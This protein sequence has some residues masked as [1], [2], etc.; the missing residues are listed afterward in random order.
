MDIHF[1]IV[2]FDAVKHRG[3]VEALWREVFTYDSPRNMPTLVIAKKCA[4]RD[5]L[6]FVASSGDA[7]V[8]TVTP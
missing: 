7:V 6:F 8:G 2:E 1:S 4:V 3:Q 5:R